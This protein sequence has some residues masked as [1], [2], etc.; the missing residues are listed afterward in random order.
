MYNYRMLANRTSVE[1]VTVATT[2]S[3]A[4]ASASWSDVDGEPVAVFNIAG[5]L[6]RHRRHVLARR[7]PV[8]EGEIDGHE[9][10]CPRHGARFDLRQRQGL[11]LPAVVDIPA[12]PVRVEGDQIQVGLPLGVGRATLA[13]AGCG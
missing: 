3:S 8:A 7:R 1:F 4:T 2:T 11:S 6:L 12:Y 13:L 9:I 10:E 5:A